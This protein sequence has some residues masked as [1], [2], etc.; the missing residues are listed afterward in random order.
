MQGET[1]PPGDP[2]SVPSV[3]DAWETLVTGDARA[4]AGVRDLVENSWRRCL[5]TGV[6]PAGREAPLVCSE[7][8]LGLRRERAEDL[9]GA[10]APVMGDA[11]AFLAETGTMMVLADPDGVVLDVEGDGRTRDRGEVIRLMPG[12]DWTETASGTNAIGTALALGAPVQIHAVEHFC[13]GIKQWTCS[14]AVI[15]DPVDRTALGVLDISGLSGAHNAHCLALAVTAAGRIE[16]RIAKRDLNLR[17]RLIEA[18]LSEERWPMDRLV[19]F[20]HRGRPVRIGDRARRLLKEMALDPARTGTG[21]AALPD[22]LKIEAAEPVFDAARRI[23]AVCVVPQGRPHLPGGARARDLTPPPICERPADPF[24][25]V[26]GDS[27]PMIKAKATAR[28]LAGVEVPVLL[29]G[30][31]G[32]GKEVFARAI[33]RASAVGQGAFVAVNCGALARD[34]LATELFGYAEGAFTGARKG[35]MAGKFEAAHDGTLFLDEIGEMPA[36][37]QAHLLRVLEQGAVVRVG[38]A[39]ERPVRVRLIAATHRDLPAEV[40]AGRFRADLYFRIAVTAI[41]LPPLAERGPDIARL[42]CHFAASAARRH[43]L[44]RHPPSDEALARLATHDW[45]GNVRELRNVIEQ[46]TILTLA[47]RIEAADLPAT[48]GA[49]HV[50]RPQPA[51]TAVS[52]DE[53]EVQAILAAATETGWN[54]AATARRLGIAKSTLYEKLRRHGIRRPGG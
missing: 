14:A 16:G 3:F 48:I 24:D 47:D 23:G 4:V 28:R 53:A 25:E 30:P 43:G 13:A 19:V 27:P 10:A 20:D 22:W 26:I 44:V 41:T 31:T 18:V 12:A 35:G 51:E 42:A 49:G 6:D 40:A 11:R 45:P 21:G 38:E 50:L 32:T 34:L 33:H 39:H 15:R 7:D 52:L 46:A 5:K 1:Q 37:L 8:R 2:P 29:T 54:L 17:A 36:E 9:R